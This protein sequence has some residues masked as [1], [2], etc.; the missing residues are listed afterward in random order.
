MTKLEFI[1][2]WTNKGYKVIFNAK[3]IKVYRVKND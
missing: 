3:N 1:K 2:Y